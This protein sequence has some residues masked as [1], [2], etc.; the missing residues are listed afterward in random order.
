MLSDLRDKIKGIVAAFVVGLLIV[1]FAL[2]G[3]N[4]YFD[5][6]ASTLVAEGDGVEVSQS[7]FRNTF[8]QYKKN[9]PASMWDNPVIKGQVLDSLIADTLS[10]RNARKRGYRVGDEALRAHIQE[11]PYFQSNGK[12]DSEIYK[13]AL[14]SRNINVKGYEEQLRAD[15]IRQQLETVFRG[16]GFYTQAE[17]KQLLALMGQARDIEYV[18]IRPDRFTGRIQPDEAAIKSFYEANRDSYQNP[19]QVQVEYIEVSAATL[20]ADYKPAEKELRALYE[21][22]GVGLGTPEKR[23]VSHI[24][25]EAGT[26]DKVARAKI[27]DLAA[28]L[29]KGADFAALARK[30]SADPGSSAKGGDLG[31]LSPGVMVKPFEEAANQLTRKGQI[32]EVVKSQFGYHLIKLTD[33]QAAKRKPFNSARAE[34]EK[35]LRSR[36]GEERFFGL[37]EKFYN[38]VYE[39]PDTLAAAASELGLKVQKSDW[40]TRAGGKGV[41]RRPEVAAAAFHPDV[42]EQGK[43]SETLELGDTHLL[44]LRVTGHRKAQPRELR[45]VRDAIRSA[46]IRRESDKQVGELAQAVRSALGEQSLAKVAAAK[47]L[48]LESA[49]GILRDKPGKLDGRVVDAVFSAARPGNGKVTTGRVD[50]GAAGTV[51]YSLKQVHEGQAER[52]DAE[53]RKKAERLLTARRQDE[54]YQAYLAGLREAA[55]VKIHRDNL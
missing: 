19:E 52:A 29:K 9:M 5:G 40:F 41:T 26:D 18:A 45:E 51:N 43:N 10:A 14:R 2:W 6:A 20:A 47:G 7:A 32:S 22:G 36:K 17:L 49:S 3:I 21:Q 27:D 39:H 24:L 8:D 55:R 38:L 53:M 37:S 31:W 30:H 15:L 34:L 23:R 12:F 16:T 54:M 42:L 33:F 50:L 44:A 48:K 1:P 35:Q 25:V 46:L 13:T 4:S 28:Q 11:L